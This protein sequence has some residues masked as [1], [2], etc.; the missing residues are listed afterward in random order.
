[1]DVLAAFGRI[2]A[3]EAERLQGDFEFHGQ[4]RVGAT[5]E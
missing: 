1:M 5:A 4:N 3:K 2:A